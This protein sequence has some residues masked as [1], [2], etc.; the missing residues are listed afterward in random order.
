ML[1]SVIV[2]TV[3]FCARHRWLVIVV[4][5]LLMVA[6]GGLSSISIRGD[7]GLPITPSI[8]R[9]RLIG[10]DA[11]P[12]IRAPIRFMASVAASLGVAVYGFSPA[13]NQGDHRQT[14]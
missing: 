8:L 7:A 1:N 2:S 12:L 5:T 4:G 11:A 9:L 13:Y 3:D 6:T 10:R 14:G